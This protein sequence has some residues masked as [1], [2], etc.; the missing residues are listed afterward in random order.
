MDAGPMRA[1]KTTNVALPL[2]KPWKV[3][4]RYKI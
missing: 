2:E 3:V 1:M 4:P